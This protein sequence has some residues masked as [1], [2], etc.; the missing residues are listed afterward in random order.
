MNKVSIF[1][2]IIFIAVISSNINAQNLGFTP[3]ISQ[4]RIESRN[5]L[6]RLSWI[7]SPEAKGPVYIYRSARPF[8]SSVPANIRPVVVRYGAQYFIDDI[9]GMENVYYFIAASD[10]QG[11]SYELIIPFINSINNITQSDIRPA[12]EKEFYQGI[13]NLRVRQDENFVF[14]TFNTSD[15]LKKAV[16]Y[17][18]AKPVRQSQDLFDAVMLQSGTFTQYA[19]YPL[20]GSTWYYTVIFEDEISSGNMV[21]RPGI[22][23]TTSAVF[24][25]SERTAED[26]MRY[27]PL[28]FLAIGSQMPGGFLSDITSDMPLSDASIIMLKNYQIPSKL[29]LEAKNPRVYN[30]DFIA[31]TSGEDSA[32]FQIINEYFARLDWEGACINLQRYLSLPR[33]RDVEARARFY[34]GQTYYYTGNYKDALWEFLSYKSFSPVEAAGWIEAVLAAM[35]Y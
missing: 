35:V 29:P 5:N 7:D 17:R 19:D 22:N 25:Y 11:Q 21:I 30:V 32:L 13:S 16:L 33:S 12:M 6:I 9:D 24:I 31:P 10:L 23:A 28:P 18:S 3:H 15:P 20:P 14:I 27:M 26:F 4:I 1:L 34:L 8:G 2:T